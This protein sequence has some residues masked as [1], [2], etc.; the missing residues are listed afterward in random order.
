MVTAASVAAWGRFA[1]PTGDELA[2]LELVTEAAEL[3]LRTYYVMEDLDT[4]VLT[5][6]EELAVT[7]QA[8]RLWKRRDT[9]EGRSAFGGDIAVTITSMD[10]D[11]DAM[12]TPA[13]GFA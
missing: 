7:M 10:P 13:I 12:L 9:P 8:A 11:I 3:H 6:T 4:F 5:A 1:L 2:L